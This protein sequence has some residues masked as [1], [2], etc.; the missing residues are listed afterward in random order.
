MTSITDEQKC[1]DTN[2]K[3]IKQFE[4]SPFDELASIVIST[5]A[6]VLLNFGSI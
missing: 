2:L 6:G 5:P 4:R 3:I 1:I